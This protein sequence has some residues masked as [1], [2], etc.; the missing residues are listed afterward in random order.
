MQPELYAPGAYS[1]GGDA[2]AKNSPRSTQPYS[3]LNDGRATIILLVC[4]VLA[5]GCGIVSDVLLF[6]AVHYRD[7][8][9]RP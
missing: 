3:L 4:I 8:L 6:K 5:L 7:F 2:P 9:V 1:F